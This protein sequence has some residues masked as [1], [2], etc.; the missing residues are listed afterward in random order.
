[1]TLDLHSGRLIQIMI[2]HHTL[3]VD[4]I[5]H[6]KSFWA[7]LVSF[8]TADIIN[9]FDQ[10]NF[11]TYLSSGIISV[12]ISSIMT[13]LL[14]HWCVI[15]HECHVS[16][17]LSFFFLIFIY[18]EYSIKSRLSC[19]S[20]H[21]ILEKDHQIVLHISALAFPSNFNYAINR[22]LKKYFDNVTK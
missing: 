21:P 10:R 7:C 13:H 11:S 19:S 15:F 18:P 12:S 17:R 6:L 16:L 3:S 4:S 5:G 9:N 14:L 20:H 1:M 2:Q 22:K 8:I